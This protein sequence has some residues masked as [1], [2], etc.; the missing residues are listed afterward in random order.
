[1]D[2]A[3]VGIDYNSAGVELRER[4]AL[5]A[6]RG[7]SLAEVLV[8]RHGAAGCLVLSTCNRT[9]VWCSGLDGELLPLVLEETGH[10]AEHARYF[11]CRRGSEAVRYLM[12]LGCGMHSQIFGEDQIL[13]QLKEALRFSRE[14]KFAG[15]VLETLFR[16]AITAAKQ[17]KTKVRLT[18]KDTSVP[19]RAIRLLE[20]R[21]G[22]L[23]GKRCLVI[24]NGEMGRLT[25]ELLVSKGCEV[26][27]TLRRYRNGQAVI[28]Q[29][30]GII[31]YEERYHSL[32]EQDFV[33]SATLSPHYTLEA[34]RIRETG[35][36][37]GCVL[38][39]LAV[40]RD[41]DPAAR[42][43]EG[44]TVYDMDDL[45]AEPSVDPESLRAAKLLLKQ[46]ADDFEQWAD[47]R[48]HVQEVQYV[49]EQTAKLTAAKLTKPL[50]K[51]SLEKGERQWLQSE[52]EQAA[53]KSLTRLMYGM[54]KHL[55]GSEWAACIT[56]LEQTVREWTEEQK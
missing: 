10:T 51:L 47:C 17:V 28:P 12:E 7:L 18:V 39:D 3:M 55:G 23:V 14:H 1:M 30:C 38:V 24:G 37:K 6:S 13:A 36:R 34:G 49:G 53:C 4:F 40:P 19:E 52:V 31:L 29:G 35:F 32:P 20:Q 9:E 41:I 50:R 21:Y 22:G 5:T 44:L 27:M 46:A 25:A 33:F 15:P 16:T 56:A 42:A 8:R 54:R 48:S 2:V 11:V 43:L 45:G 26:L